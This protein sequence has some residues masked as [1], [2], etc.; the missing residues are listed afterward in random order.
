MVQHERVVQRAF[1]QDHRYVEEHKPG[2]K[3]KDINKLV[4]T[5]QHALLSRIKRSHCTLVEAALEDPCADDNGMESRR[6][7]CGDR[8]PFVAVKVLPFLWE[9]VLHY[10]LSNFVDR[11]EEHEE[12]EGRLRR[13]AS[14][15]RLAQVRRGHEDFFRTTHLGSRIGGLRLVGRVIKRGGAWP[16]VIGFGGSEDGCCVGGSW[17]CAVGLEED[18]TVVCYGFGFELGLDWIGLSVICW[19]SSS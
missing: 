6:D 18:Y 15:A 14:I 10:G 1:P 11:H 16:W 8:E 7:S 19:L 12:A 9:E 4:I 17:A 3:A 5:P 2:E 13:D